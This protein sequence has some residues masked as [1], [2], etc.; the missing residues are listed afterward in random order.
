MTTHTHESNTSSPPAES[1]N[2]AVVAGTAEIKTGHGGAATAARVGWAGLD[3]DEAGDHASLDEVGRVPPQPRLLGRMTTRKRASAPMIAAFA[4]DGCQ[5]TADQL[6]YQSGA[7]PNRVFV[8]DDDD[9]NVDGDGDGS[10]G[11]GGEAYSDGGVKITGEDFGD[12][13]GG[14]EEEEVV[15]WVL[16]PAGQLPP[17]VDSSLIPSEYL[18]EEV[19]RRLQE[20][21]ARAEEAQRR[22]AEERERVLA[23]MTEEEV[24]R[25]L[26]EAAAATVAADKRKKATSVAEAVSSLGSAEPTASSPAVDSEGCAQQTEVA[27]EP[28]ETAQD[29]RSTRA[30]AIDAARAN[31]TRAESGGTIGR[32]AEA[33]QAVKDIERDAVDLST[34]DLCVEPGS[35]TGDVMDSAEGRSHSSDAAQAEG[36]T[37]D[38]SGHADGRSQDAEHGQGLSPAAAENATACPPPSEFLDTSLHVEATGLARVSV[39]ATRPT[40]TCSG[41]DE[42]AAR[43][44]PEAPDTG[45]SA[46]ET[47]KHGASGDSGRASAASAAR[48]SGSG[49]G[50]TVGGG[51]RPASVGPRAASAKAIMPVTPSTGGATVQEAPAGSAGRRVATARASQASVVPGPAAA[52][53]RPASQGSVS[54]ASAAAANQR[55]ESAGR[56]V[57]EPGRERATSRK[58]TEPATRAGTAGS[59]R[60]KGERVHSAAASRAVEARAGSVRAGSAAGGR[61]GVGRPGVDEEAATRASTKPSTPRAAP[62]GSSVRQA[63]ARTRSAAAEGVGAEAG[64]GNRPSTRPASA[65]AVSGTRA[66][67][68]SAA[69]P[70][71]SAGST[72]S[73]GKQIVGAAVDLDAKSLA[74]EAL[75][76]ATG[77]ARSATVRSSAASWPAAPELP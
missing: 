38:R 25:M 26:E 48:M 53:G 28:S 54:R 27:A 5:L 46:V 50:G 22:A 59:V 14:D 2:G 32:A 73:A 64:S 21:A 35:G 41:D 40:T 10:G 24:T 58:G 31:S 44:A 69:A 51:S 62:A 42:G 60:Q 61:G 29:F 45:A 65:A 76:A 34:N 9:D 17:G 57:A 1:N 19:E 71:K 15:E 56:G 11:S 36:M 7:D 16:L 52:A 30:S 70:Q 67:Q 23:G 66:S 43:A 33:S 68:G 3:K 18:P 6:T 13:V 47:T 75:R 20:E 49:G 55:A 72:R 4:D 39:G 77:S 63:S 8:Q 74:G 37:T 12:E